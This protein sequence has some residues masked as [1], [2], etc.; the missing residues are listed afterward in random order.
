MLQLNL[1]LE[2]DKMESGYFGFVA[3]CVTQPLWPRR[4]PL[5]CNVSDITDADY[6]LRRKITT[7]ST[8]YS[9]PTTFLTE[10]RKETDVLCTNN[11]QCHYFY[12]YFEQILLYSAIVNKILLIYTRLH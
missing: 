10:T 11:C 8:I 12:D 9:T 1:P 6:L 4:V 2:Q 3:I 7:S 5:N